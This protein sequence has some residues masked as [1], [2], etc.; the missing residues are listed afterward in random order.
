MLLSEY[1][2][3]VDLI[4]WIDKHKSHLPDTYP[5]E[6]RAVLAIGSF[7]VALEHQKAI[8]LLHSSSLHGSMLALFRALPES[9]IRGLWLLHCATNIE[10]EKFKEGTLDKSFGS[11]IK[12]IEN[13]MGKPDSAF[14]AFKINKW[15]ALNDFTHTGIR[16]VVRRFAPDSISPNYPEDEIVST[17]IDAIALG[18]IAVGQLIG[19]ADRQDLM[20]LFVED[21]KSHPNEKLRQLISEGG[22]AR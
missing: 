20:A 2:A 14:S 6:G 8:A 12:E 21:M 19:L 5:V 11:L 7:E 16:Q 4:S 1:V 10:I 17:L 18:I 3:L 15:S 22:S 9:T 13:K